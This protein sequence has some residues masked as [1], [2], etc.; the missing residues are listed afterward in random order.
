MLTGLL[1]YTEYSVRVSG[2]NIFTP[3]AVAD[4]LFGVLN[5]FTTLPGGMLCGHTMHWNSVLCVCVCVCV[6]V[7]CGVCVCVRVCGVCACLCGVCM[8]MCGV[9]VHVHTVGLKTY[10]FIK[11]IHIYDVTI[12]VTLS[13]CFYVLRLFYSMTNCYMTV[14]LFCLNGVRF[15]AFFFYQFVFWKQFITE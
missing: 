3:A 5:T 15:T 6:C 4:N 8:H 11:C 1:A 10:F 12:Y 9:C 2:R 14:P 7:W 13:F